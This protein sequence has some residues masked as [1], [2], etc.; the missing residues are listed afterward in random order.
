MDLI[1]IEKF[2]CN[3]NQTKTLFVFFF[4]YLIPWKTNKTRLVPTTLSSSH[5]SVYSRYFMQ[6]QTVK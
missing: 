2:D 1:I 5:L 6:E 4:F 3:N